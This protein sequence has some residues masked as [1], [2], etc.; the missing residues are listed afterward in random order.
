MVSQRS[1]SG[2]GTLAAKAGRGKYDVFYD[3]L[4]DVVCKAVMSFMSAGCSLAVLRD[5]PPC[6]CQI[7]FCFLSPQVFVLFSTFGEQAYILGGVNRVLQQILSFLLCQDASQKGPEV[8]H[9]SDRAR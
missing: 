8:L 1:E 4:Y 5:S 9:R 6:L 7:S 3:V 2:Q